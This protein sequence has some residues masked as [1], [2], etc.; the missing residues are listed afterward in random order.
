MEAIAATPGFSTER[1]VRRLK[2]L[3][4]QGRHDEALRGAQELIADFPENRDLLLIAASSLR[5]LGRIDQALGMLDRLANSHPRFSLMY[6]ERGL[7]HVARKDAPQAIDALLRA[8]NVNP[9]L[10]L[11][12]RMLEGVYRL[13]G[14]TKNTETAAAHV[15]TLKALPPEVV[16]ATALFSDGELTPAE[17]IIRAFLLKHGNHVEAMRLL[18]KIGVARDVLDDAELLL[19]G[20]L[21][22]APDHRAARYDYADVLLKR[23]KYREA[24]DQI[25]PL[26]EL[27]P[28]NPNYLTVAASAAVGLGRTRRQSRSIKTFW[29][30]P[31]PR[32]CIS[33]WVTH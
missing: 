24:R 29:R 12:W 6:Q 23:H 15:A 16:T 14:D 26:L 28:R 32:M 27:E 5:H 19:E 21:T 18:A 3:Q 30:S 22:L 25:R 7:C 4:K 8:V 9:A 2:D 31:P 1:E 13:T 20:V 33:G 10:P 17:E 11:S